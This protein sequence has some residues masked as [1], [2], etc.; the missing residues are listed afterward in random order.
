VVTAKL[1]KRFTFEAGHSLPQH[2]GKCKYVHGHSFKLDVCIHGNLNQEI[3]M[4]MDYKDIKDI[5]QPI[6][7]R[8]DHSFLNDIFKDPTSENIGKYIYEYLYPEFE[9]N[10]CTL[11]YIDVWET[12]DSHCRIGLNDT[13]ILQ[14]E[15]S[16]PYAYN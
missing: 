16:Y 14:V 15:G 10:G 1:I 9:K 5:V 4:V 13:I 3:G 6:I 7:D 2:K 8:L 11:D 12:E